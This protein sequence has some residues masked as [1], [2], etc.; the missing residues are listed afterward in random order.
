MRWRL[1]QLTSLVGDLP[2]AVGEAA[3]LGLSVSS[4]DDGTTASQH[5]ISNAWL[6]L[7]SSILEIAT[8]TRQSD[9]THRFHERFGDGGY[10]VILQ[11]NDLP[12]ARAQLEASG[13]R[14]T[15]EID[16]EDAKELHLD[17]RDVGGTILAIDWADPPGAWRWAGPDWPS[18][19]RTHVVTELLAAEIAVPDPQETAARWAEILQKQPVTAQNDVRL[20]PLERGV[21][22]FI[23]SSEHGR[24][25]LVG[26][27]LGAAPGQQVGRE[28]NAAGLRFRLVDSL[29]PAAWWIG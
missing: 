22:R 10:M 11:T 1:R 13:V 28:I 3:E 7:G 21:L 26:G 20:I 5:G 25:R 16:Q 19:V 9:A 12:A 24:G 14:V 23:P 8:P 4:R 6:P 29:A 15:W 18:H 17:H 27:D 2:A